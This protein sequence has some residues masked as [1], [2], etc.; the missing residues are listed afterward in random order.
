MNDD[1]EAARWEHTL[2]V[3]YLKRVTAWAY[4]LYAEARARLAY[5]K[6]GKTFEITAYKARLLNGCHPGGDDDP[7]PPLK[8]PPDWEDKRNA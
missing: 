2:E 5:V 8:P 3:A 1:P 6:T 7:W 4:N